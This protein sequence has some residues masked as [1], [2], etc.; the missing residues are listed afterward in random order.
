MGGGWARD[1]DYAED[2]VLIAVV[3]APLGLKISRESPRQSYT[4]T[5]TEIP[6]L[7]LPSH[8]TL[9][10]LIELCLDEKSEQPGGDKS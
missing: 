5:T 10:P 4:F 6:L 9:Q 8:H 1:E 2:V 7:H 3:W